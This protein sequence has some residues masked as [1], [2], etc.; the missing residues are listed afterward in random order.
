MA[1][2]GNVI[3]FYLV[4]ISASK[5]KQEIYRIIKIHSNT[6]LERQYSDMIHL[7]CASISITRTGKPCNLTATSYR[8]SLVDLT[9]RIR[10]CRLSVNFQLPA[11]TQIY[12]KIY[13]PV[14][15]TVVLCPHAIFELLLMTNVITLVC[16][17]KK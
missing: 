12:L 10:A 14:L 7:L 2:I 13:F 16:I 4:I 5:K 6:A 11:S 9:I 3:F 17:L 8:I 1:F 15:I